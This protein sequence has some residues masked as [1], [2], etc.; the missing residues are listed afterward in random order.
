MFWFYIGSSASDVQIVTGGKKVAKILQ[1]ADFQCIKIRNPLHRQARGRCD[2]RRKFLLARGPLGRM[3]CP[4]GVG[5]VTA[6]G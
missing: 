3:N 1:L 6:S 5:Y 2:A 4:W